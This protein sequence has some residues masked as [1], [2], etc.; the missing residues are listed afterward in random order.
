MCLLFS[1]L[2]GWF[3]SSL[4]LEN[5]IQS[6]VI[7][8]TTSKREKQLNPHKPDSN[9][10]DAE[11]RGQQNKWEGHFSTHVGVFGMASVEAEKLLKIRNDESSL[12]GRS[13]GELLIH[14]TQ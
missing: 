1:M 4:D 3:K 2:K 9:G 11:P 6:V 5:Q 14:F 10:L 13:S 8:K 7:F 12:L